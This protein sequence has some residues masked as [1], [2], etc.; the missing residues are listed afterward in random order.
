MED[1]TELLD[2]QIETENSS[3][4]QD[5][6]S[7]SDTPTED[8]ETLKQL[9]KQL[10]ARAKKAEG[11]VLINGEWVKPEK[12]AP[13]VEPKPE[14]LNNLG[15]SLKD[16]RALQ[17]VHDDDVDEVTEFAKFKGISIA[18]AKK[19]PV[20]Q[21]LL[22]DNAEKRASAQAANTGPSKRGTAKVSQE[23]LLEKFYSNEDMTAEERERIV[24]A[25]FAQKKAHNK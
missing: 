21:N 18:E 11:F 16:I 5:D 19:L 8:V 12:P 9:N 2:S 23:A 17:D 20:I 24:E 22:K 13:K 14:V 4:A 15:M 25:R 3:T 6:T 1:T 10:F 7:V